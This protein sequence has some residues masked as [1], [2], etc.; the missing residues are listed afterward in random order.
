MKNDIKKLII[1]SGGGTMGPVTPLLGMAAGIKMAAKEKRVEIDFLWL[2]TKSGPEREFIQKEGMEFKAIAS[3]KLRRYF[4]FKNISD[5]ARIKLGFW[6]SLLIFIKRKPAVFLSAGGFVSVPAAWAA[7]LLRVPVIIHQQDARPGLANKLMA[8]AAKKIT[9][10]FESS[11]SDYGSKAEWIGNSVRKEMTSYKITKRESRQK[12]GLAQEMPVLFVIGGG[13][14]ASAINEMMIRNLP[15]L[16]KFCQ[17]VHVTG[18][19][20]ITAKKFISGYFPFE[21]MHVDGVIKAFTSADA[22]LSR[23]GMGVLTELCFLAK[24]SIL[25]PIPASHQEDNAK[26]FQDKSAAVVLDQ[27]SLGDEQLVAEIKELLLNKEKQN[28]L[29]TRIKTVIKTGADERMGELVLEAAGEQGDV[30]NF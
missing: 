21:I 22:V 23:C 9:T 6:Q 24:P 17:I 10:T 27:L 5:I 14:G 15:E 28:E 20:K 26:I 8:P 18:K 2:G 29:S 3:G 19:G 13:T 4:S 16:L 1:L 30:Q 25:I 11:L 12:I 7:R